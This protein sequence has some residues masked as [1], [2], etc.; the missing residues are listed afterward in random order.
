MNRAHLGPFLADAELDALVAVSLENVLYS[1]NVPIMTQRM[2][3]SRLAFVVWTPDDEATMIVCTIEEAQ[4]RAESWITDVRGYVEFADSPMAILADVLRERGLAGGRIGIETAYLGHR[5]H[6]EL[7]G[8]LPG[9]TLLDG[10]EVFDA[11]RLVKA[12]HELETL[13]RA[14]ITTERAIRHAFTTAAIAETEAVVAD[15]M[16]AELRRGGADGV[17]FTVLATGPNAHLVHP[18]PGQEKLDPGN[19]LRTDFGGH[20]GAPYAG[21][22]SDLARTAVVGRATAGQRDTYA[23]LFEVHAFAPRDAPSRGTSLRRLRGGAARLRGTWSR[24]PHAARRTQHRPVHPRDADAQPE[25]DR[26]AAG[27][28]GDGDRADHDHQRRDL[29]RRGHDP[30]HGDRRPAAL[31]RPRLGRPAGDRM[32]S[33]AAASSGELGDQVVAAARRVVRVGVEP[34]VVRAGRLIDATGA[35]PVDDG[36]VIV[37]GRRITYAGTAAGARTCRARPFITSRTRPCCRG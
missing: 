18:S 19:V 35:E 10:D 23:R 3:P 26:R 13:E 12:P 8:L 24:L 4:V 16:A 27:G 20:F 15:R 21:Y 22:L 9:A 25:D 28:D 6:A 11:A 32:S 1:S 17:A 37:E 7:A 14:A 34:F 31:L 36:A 5:Y 29:P 2:I 30:D 33:V